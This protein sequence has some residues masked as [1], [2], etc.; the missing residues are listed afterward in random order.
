MATFARGLGRALNAEYVEFFKAFVPAQ[1][2]REEEIKVGAT[3]CAP[4][5]AHLDMQSYEQPLTMTSH[6]C[7]STTI[8]P[9]PRA[10][11]PSRRWH[12]LHAVDIWA[13]W[14]AGLSQELWQGSFPLASEQHRIGSFAH[15]PL[16]VALAPIV[17]SSTPDRLLSSLPCSVKQLMLSDWCV[18]SVLP[19]ISV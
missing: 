11:Q 18:W 17:P 12:C 9:R 14:R 10:S 16:P 3:A 2:V 5:V 1:H 13:G 8:L 15:D 4:L 19:C 6:S 7:T